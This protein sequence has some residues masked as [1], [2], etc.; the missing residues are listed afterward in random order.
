MRT[1]KSFFTALLLLVFSVVVGGCAKQELSGAKQPFDKKALSELVENE[2]RLVLYRKKHDIK[3]NINSPSVLIDG[4]VLGALNPNQYMVGHVCEGEGLFTLRQRQDGETK[5]PQFKYE[6]ASK[7]TL[8]YQI[9]STS[10]GQYEVFAVPEEQALKDLKQVRYT[11]FLTSRSAKNCE[12]QVAESNQVAPTSTE[13]AVSQ[14][15]TLIDES[16]FAVDVLFRFDSAVLVRTIGTHSTDA[17]KALDDM[18]AALNNQQEN[19][20][21]VRVVGHTDRL[22][23]KAYNQALSERRAKAVANYLVAKGVKQK[24]EIVGKGSQ[25]P[26]TTDCKGTR[27][28]VELIECLQPD[29]R[30]SVELWGVQR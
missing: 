11:S 12:E 14:D 26:V 24:L 6:A 13:K 21:K 27:A 25:Q 30:V 19:V 23:A 8:Y 20:E 18:A 2:A 29:R 28:T 15:P 17:F 1:K 5:T 3:H 7:D 22:G 4:R 16:T 9:R 10:Q